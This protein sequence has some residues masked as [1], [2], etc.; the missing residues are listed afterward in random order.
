MSSHVF[1]PPR[2]AKRKIAEPRSQEELW[3]VRRQLDFSSPRPP[4]NLPIPPTPRKKVK[5]IV[6]NLPADKLTFVE[7]PT[8]SDDERQYYSLHVRPKYLRYEPKDLINFD[9]PMLQQ[10]VEWYLHSPSQPRNSAEWAYMELVGQ[11]AEELEQF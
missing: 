5:K 9:P 4:S 1:E 11:F 7:T 8:L 2:L 10:I 6:R 3:K